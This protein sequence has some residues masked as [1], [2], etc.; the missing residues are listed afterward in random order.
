MKNMKRM[1]AMTL[2]GVVLSGSALAK[3]LPKPDADDPALAANGQVTEDV[4]AP[5][6]GAFT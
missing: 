5:E 2:I 1:A 4:K 6:T 3:D